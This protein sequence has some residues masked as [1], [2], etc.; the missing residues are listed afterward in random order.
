MTQ[1]EP[2]LTVKSHGPVVRVLPDGRVFRQRYKA[3]G[4]KEVEATLNALC[5]ASRVDPGG[6]DRDRQK[7]GR[8]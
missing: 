5:R 6:L 7:R 3:P 2:S 8:L 4:R 1:T